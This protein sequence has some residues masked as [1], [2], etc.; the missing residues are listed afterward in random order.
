[1]AAEAMG[2]NLAATS[3]WPSAS[4]PFFAGVGGGLLPCSIRPGQ[5]TTFTRP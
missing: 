3:G 4:A 2:I 5:A 1:M